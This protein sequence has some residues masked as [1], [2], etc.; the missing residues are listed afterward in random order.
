MTGPG[1]AG[2]ASITERMLDAHPAGL[3]GTFRDALLE[4][5]EACLSCAQACAACA[6]A[7][8]AEDMVAELRRCIRLDTDCADVCRTTA[9]LLARRTG[10]GDPATVRALLDAC[11]LACAACAA[12]CEGHADHHAHCAICAEAC[13]RCE[14]ACQKLLD[15]MS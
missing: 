4:C 11:R 12:E 14:A 3:V 8:L 1:R 5:I 13:R 6:D 2:A 9:A 10:D 15:A 7:C